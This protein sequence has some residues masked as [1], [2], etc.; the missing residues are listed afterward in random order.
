MSPP[1]KADTERRQA[2]AED[3]A[4]RLDR[5]MSVLG[6]LFLL[7][8][9]GQ[10]IATRTTMVTVL[11]VLS[12][13]LWLVFVGEYALRLYV[14]PDRVTFLRRTWW[15]LVFLV[16]PFL[17]FLRLAGIG[18]LGRLGRVLSSTVRG[19]RSAGRLLSSRVAWLASLSAIV[20]LAGSQ[21]LYTFT[22]YPS[23]AAA[24][25]DAALATVTGETVAAEGPVA[26]VIEV[27]LAV[28]SVVVFATLAASLGAYFLQN[29]QQERQRDRE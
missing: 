19:S 2:W 11:S 9:L 24:L 20:A 14:A 17:R 23:Y 6:V 16:V 5:P 10:A 25:H 1:A 7:V 4:D 26:R 22:T 3:L 29:G 18:R 12:W 15:Q 28:Y 13:S 21:L 27:V 8:V